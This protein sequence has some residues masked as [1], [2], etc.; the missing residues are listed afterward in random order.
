MKARVFALMLLS[1]AMALTLCGGSFAQNQCCLTVSPGVAQPSDH[2]WQFDPANPDQPNLMMHAKLCLKCPAGATGSVPVVGVRLTAS[3]TGNDQADI[4]WIRVTA[5]IN[6]NGIVDPGEPAVTN[7]GGFPADNGNLQICTT[8][9]PPTL[10][11]V[12]PDRCLCLLIEYGLKS[13]APCNAT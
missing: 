4:A 2:T 6:C 9:F 3:G 11:L 5:D 12:S 8:A 10:V 7:P 13:I 1:V